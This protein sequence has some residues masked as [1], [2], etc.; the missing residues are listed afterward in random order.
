MTKT[1]KQDGQ[2]LL[3]YKFKAPVAIPKNN[4]NMGSKTIRPVMVN[5]TDGVIFSG[6]LSGEF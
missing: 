4:R 1:S 5:P 6:G 3:T 2:K